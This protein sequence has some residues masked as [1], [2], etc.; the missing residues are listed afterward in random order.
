MCC[1]A[2][3]THVFDVSAEVS[4]GNGPVEWAEP[5]WTSKYRRKGSPE[6]RRNDRTTLRKARL[7]TQKHGKELGGPFLR[8]EKK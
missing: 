4:S 7:G 6:A 8:V 2:S 3:H 5:D 1:G